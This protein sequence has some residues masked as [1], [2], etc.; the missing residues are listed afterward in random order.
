MA[1][2]ATRPHSESSLK[3]R[4]LRRMRNANSISPCVTCSGVTVYFPWRLNYI[5]L[6]PSGLVCNDRPGNVT[7]TLPASHACPSAKALKGLSGRP[8]CGRQG[9]AE[10]QIIAVLPRYLHL[11]RC[12]AGGP[13]RDRGA[14]THCLLTINI[15]WIPSCFLGLPGSLFYY[16]FWPILLITG[17][18]WN[19]FFLLLLDLRK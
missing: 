2:K 17:L 10:G 1:A 6:Q 18:K 3:C 16:F 19:F 14:D 9:M 5:F 8:S 7:G 4:R 11:P 15:L 12:T 13:S